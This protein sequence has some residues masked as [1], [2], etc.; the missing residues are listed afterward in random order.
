[1][2]RVP[3][4]FLQLQRVQLQHL[5]QFSTA[6]LFGGLDHDCKDA[7]NYEKNT[8]TM[9]YQFGV[10]TQRELNR[11]C[12]SQSKHPSFALSNAVLISQ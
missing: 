5:S 6:V 9:P 1:M 7:F 12:E 10:P 11:W 4:A 2:A 8:A 3:D